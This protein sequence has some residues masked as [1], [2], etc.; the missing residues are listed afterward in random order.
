MFVIETGGL[1]ALSFDISMLSSNSKTGQNP[2]FQSNC[3]SYKFFNLKA[4]GNILWSFM[5]PNH[6]KFLKLL[7]HFLT[8]K[9]DFISWINLCERNLSFRL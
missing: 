3:L 8:N 5:S 2:I 7:D 9:T 4:G 1:H 6:H